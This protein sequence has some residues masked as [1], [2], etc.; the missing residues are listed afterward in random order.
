MCFNFPD[1][2]LSDHIMSI[3]SL[4]HSGK[5]WLHGL[6]IFWMCKKYAN[7]AHCNHVTQ[8]ILNVTTKEWLKHLLVTFSGKSKKYWVFTDE[9]HCG[10]MIQYFLNIL[11]VYWAGKSQAHY[12]VYSERIQHVLTQVSVST[13]DMKLLCTK[14]VLAQYRELCPQW[15]GRETTERTK[16]KAKARARAG[17]SKDRDEDEGESG[18]EGRR[19]EVQRQRGQ[20]LERGR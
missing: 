4:S 11:T 17:A 19:L 7:S 1:S 2:V 13:L 14:H 16:A 9:A 12:S 10:H 15:E 18:S 5:M 20:G 3:F 6:S 8:Y